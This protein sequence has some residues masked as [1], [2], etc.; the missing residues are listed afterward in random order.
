MLK[1]SAVQGLRQLKQESWI[2]PDE[3][4]AWDMLRSRVMHGSLV[5]PYSIAKEDKL[6]LD[7]ASLFH[8]LTRR[9]LADVDPDPVPPAELQINGP[10]VSDTAAAEQIGGGSA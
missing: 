3:F 6:L 9:L 5:S 10:G 2:T 7:L 8:A 4:D 1:T